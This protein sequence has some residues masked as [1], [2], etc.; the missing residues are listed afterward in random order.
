[1]MV[2]MAV[3]WGTL[4]FNVLTQ[5]MPR[6]S[7]RA[8]EILHGEVQH[9][10]GDD[11][12]GR[13]QREIALKRLHKLRQ[14]RGTPVPLEELRDT[15]VDLFPDFSE[16]ILKSADRANRPPVLPW[17]RL[18]F[19]AIALGGLTSTLWLLNLPYP[20][21]RYPV[22]RI[23]PIVLLPSFI[24]MDS[25]YRQ[26]IAATEQADQLINQATSAA[27]ID[28]GAA[29]VKLAQK[30]LDALPVWTLGYYPQTYCG[31]SGCSWRFTL[32]EFEQV[33]REVA[34]MDA[35]VFQEQNAQT[36]LQQAEQAIDAAREKYQE[37]K[38]FSDRRMALAQWQQAIDLFA[39][40]PESTIA[41]HIARVK[42]KSY[43]RD[44]RQVYP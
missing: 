40:I 9:L 7:D 11:P 32:D 34:R 19:V 1:M 30:N 36:Q 31:W 21:I 25:H 16:R 6:L 10:S 35:K 13:I 24:R 43:E 29:Q 12:I 3:P 33:R 2:P 42:L 17:Q 27:D 5:P 38:D 39:L 37:S 14:Q 44:F 15:I 20:M 26:A 28:R 23:A 4:E 18:K 22:S 41:G 8:F